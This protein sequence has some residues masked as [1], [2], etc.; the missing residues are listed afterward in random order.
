MKIIHYIP[1][2][3]P[4]VGGTSTYMQVLAKPLGTMAK[5]LSLST[6][7]L[8]EMG[9]NGRKLIEEKYSANVMAQG[10]I[11]VYNDCLKV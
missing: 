2:I 11:N 3:D 10:M 9:R 5:F 7:K 6:E 8:E 1:S 4:M